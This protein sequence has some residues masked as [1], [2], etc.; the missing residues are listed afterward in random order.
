MPKGRLHT[1]SGFEIMEMKPDT[2]AKFTTVYLSGR[3]E[4]TQGGSSISYQD[5]SIVFDSRSSP[6]ERS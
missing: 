3:K 4:S 6:T 2:S 1:N 5:F